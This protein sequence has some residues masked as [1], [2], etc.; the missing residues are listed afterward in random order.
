ME[1]MGRWKSAACPDSRDSDLSEPAHYAK[2]QLAER[3]GDCKV[4]G[5]AG[6]VI[7][8]SQL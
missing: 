1:S 7:E 3:G 2:A 4:Q 8:E 6:E 5:E